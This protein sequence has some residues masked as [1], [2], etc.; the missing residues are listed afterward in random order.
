MSA[1]RSESTARRPA[2]VLTRL[3]NRQVSATMKTFDS[4]PKPN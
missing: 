1:M 2:M 4:M 3:G